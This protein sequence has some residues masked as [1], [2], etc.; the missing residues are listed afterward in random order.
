MTFKENVSD[1]KIA[2]KYFKEFIRRLNRLCGKKLVYVVVPEVQVRGAIHFHSLFFN[3]EFMPNVYDVLID[4]W[5]DVIGGV[6]SV[7]FLTPRGRKDFVVGY[8]A[9]YIS[10]GFVAGSRV[11]SYSFSRSALHPFVSYDVRHISF[12]MDLINSKPI[13]SSSFFSSQGECEFSIYSLK[14]SPLSLLSRVG[15][16]AF[17][18]P[19]GSELATFED[20]PP[21]SVPLPL[22]F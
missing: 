7:N 13:Y 11:R 9:K 1:L 16:S 10:K 5:R 6:G 20:F 21:I 18:S 17:S 3:F 19:F 14:R 2:N 12:C 22:D 8:L 4:L 15:L